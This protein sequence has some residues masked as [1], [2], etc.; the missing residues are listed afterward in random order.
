M[1]WA[2]STRQQSTTRLHIS[3]YFGGDYKKGK[4]K[5]T[6]RLRLGWFYMGKKSDAVSRRRI[7]NQSLCSNNF[8]STFSQLFFLL[9][10]TLCGAGAQVSCPGCVLS[11]PSLLAGKGKVRERRPGCCGSPAKQWLKHP[12][13]INTLLVTNINHWTIQ[14]SEK[15]INWVSAKNS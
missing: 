4:S 3:W 8:G 12:C 5:K 2:N 1:W 6:H 7:F 15:K 13:V 10:V 9:S 11:K 14:A